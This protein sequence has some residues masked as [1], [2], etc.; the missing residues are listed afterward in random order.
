MTQQPAA[1]QSLLRVFAVAIVAAILMS[2]VGSF[3]AWL[4]V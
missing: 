4:A 2:F 3:F 1:H